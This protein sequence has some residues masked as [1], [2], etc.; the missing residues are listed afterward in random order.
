M[1]IKIL[2]TQE[3]IAC[4][5][6]IFDYYCKEATFK[7]AEKLVNE[8]VDYAE[9]LITK[10]ALGASEEQLKGRKRKYHYLVCKNNKIIYW[11]ENNIIFIATVF[12]TRR[13]PKKIKKG[14]K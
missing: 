10:P 8:I 9:I 6:D 2:W 13:N 4:L 5:K 14:L 3:A 11:K 12:D 1:E 7:I